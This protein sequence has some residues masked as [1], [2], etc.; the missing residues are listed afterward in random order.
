V[1]AVKNKLRQDT[2]GASPRTNLRCSCATPA[3]MR[4]TPSIGKRPEDVSRRSD[5]RYSAL[6]RHPLLR[7]TRHS[8]EGGNPESQNPTFMSRTWLLLFQKILRGT[9]S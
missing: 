5:P 1:V 7:S 9:L 3:F 2:Y 8:R 6:L 4:S